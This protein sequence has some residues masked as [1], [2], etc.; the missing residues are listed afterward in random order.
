MIYLPKEFLVGFQR[1]ENRRG[2][3]TD[4]DMDN[5]YVLGFAT[6]KD[7]KGVIRQKKTW[8]SWRHEDNP[9]LTFPNNSVQGFRIIGYE[10][11]SGGGWSSTG[12]SVFD[13]EDPRGFI[14]QINS[15]NLVEIIRQCKIDKGIVENKCLWAWEG[16]QLMLI[17]EGT[18]LY[19]QG[20]ESFRLKG[21]K[22]S[23]SD[24]S[25]GDKVRMQ[26]GSEGI[27]YGAQYTTENKPFSYRS[28]YSEKITIGDQ[29]RKFFFFNLKGHTY[30]NGIGKLEVKSNFNISEIIEKA[31]PP[32]SE[33]Q[34][35]D[36][37]MKHLE[38]VFIMDKKNKGKDWSTRDKALLN[39]WEYDWT[40]TCP[41]YFAPKKIKDTEE[42]KDKIAHTI[43]I[44]KDE[45]LVWTSE[46]AEEI[47]L[48]ERNR[49][50]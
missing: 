20:V 36:L 33:Q 2:L 19:H 43:G 9:I 48:Q 49:P 32:L 15:G 22:I 4:T 39:G 25:I 10:T 45:I 24:V 17:P 14:L 26:D 41:L 30:N 1:R 11:R 16:T 38:Y 13:V 35:A 47:R 50:W 7:E 6:Y 29:K 12:R 18:D 5:E 40:Y 37:L 21:Q 34:V 8:D 44:H 28:L 42:L 31:N 23:P 27:W 46:K 3:T